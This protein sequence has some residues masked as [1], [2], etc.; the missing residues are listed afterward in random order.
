MSNLPNT[1]A[2]NV[3]LEDEWLTISF[4]QPE[5]RNNAETYLGKYR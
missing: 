2:C 5:K 3:Q 4:N 1:K